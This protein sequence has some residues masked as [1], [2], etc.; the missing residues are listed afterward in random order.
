[1]SFPLTIHLDPAGQRLQD[2]FSV[3]VTALGDD[4]ALS[5]VAD[6]DTLV[7]TLELPSAPRFVRL[8]GEFE[9]DGTGSQCLDQIVFMS[10]TDH[11]AV[12]LVAQGSGA[13]LVLERV[14]PSGHATGAQ[15]GWGVGLLLVLGLL[16]LQLG[17]R[18]RT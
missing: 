8:Q 13:D 4:R 1:M 18:A 10:A 6:G 3:T 17:S 7:G 5:L 12:W 15:L 9:Q 16:W 14:C 2:P 11:E